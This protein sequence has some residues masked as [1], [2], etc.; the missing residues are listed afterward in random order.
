MKPVALPFALLTLLVP[1]LAFACGNAMFRDYA[2][3]AVDYVALSPMTAGLL[4]MAL[5]FADRSTVPRELV[6]IA[7]SYIGALGVGLL[8]AERFYLVNDWLRMGVLTAVPL[9]LSI[10]QYTK[11]RRIGAAVLAGATVMGG[12]CLALLFL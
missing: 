5:R 6:L 10:S 12:A 8:L 7:T 1:A 2:P 3:S 4:V 11:R 9:L